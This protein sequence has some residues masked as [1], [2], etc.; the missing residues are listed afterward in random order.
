MK[1]EEIWMISPETH[2]HDAIVVYQD[3]DP[4]SVAEL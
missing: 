4:Y 3:S 2:H 1:L